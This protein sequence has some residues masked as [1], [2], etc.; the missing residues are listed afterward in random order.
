MAYKNK[1][2]FALEQILI[3]IETLDLPHLISEIFYIRNTD[4]L[5]SYIWFVLVVGSK[6]FVV[7][8][9]LY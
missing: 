5:G 4:I 6:K 2:Y 9:Y 7:Y 8:I 1:D 3:K